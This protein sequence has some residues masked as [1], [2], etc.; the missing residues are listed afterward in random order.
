M[1]ISH[2]CQ[3]RHFGILESDRQKLGIEAHAI[4][5]SNDRNYAEGPREHDIADELTDLFTLS[6]QVSLLSLQCTTY[7]PRQS[8][9]SHR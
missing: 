2:V 5:L 1:T 9:G 4:N 6:T 8:L 7:R 3:K